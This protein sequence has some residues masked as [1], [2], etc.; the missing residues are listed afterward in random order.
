MSRDKDSDLGEKRPSRKETTARR[1]AEYLEAIA[2]CYRIEEAC[3]QTGIATST[4]HAWRRDDPQFKKDFEAA[5]NQV[6][7]KLEEEALRRATA[8]F[9]EECYQGGRLAGTITRKSDALLL[10]LLKNLAPEKYGDKKEVDVNVKGEP[11][12]FSIGGK[13]YEF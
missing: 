4:I 13:K 8:G 1:K 6:L 12:S 7:L 10:F 11:Q 5:R 2:D 3:R 9:K